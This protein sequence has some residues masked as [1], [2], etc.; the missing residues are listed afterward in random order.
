MEAFF[1]SASALSDFE[2]MEKIQD[3]IKL[4]WA[5]PVAQVGAKPEQINL[6][7]KSNYWE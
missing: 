7:T 5:L 2:K 6:L 1:G 3:K 4:M